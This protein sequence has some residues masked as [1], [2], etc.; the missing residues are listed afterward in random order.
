MK[1]IEDRLKE[2]IRSIPPADI[3]IKD[4]ATV[5]FATQEVR[6]SVIEEIIKAFSTLFREAM[7]DIA[8]GLIDDR[9]TIEM[10]R[11]RIEDKGNMWN[12]VDAMNER[13]VLLIKDFLSVID[14]QRATIAHMALDNG[15]Q[16]GYQAGNK[17]GFDEGYAQ[18]WREVD[19]DSEPDE[20]CDSDNDREWDSLLG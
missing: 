5:P 9:P 4:Y 11:S 20:D 2:V 1:T 19:R 8:C 13:E 6:D 10:A 3:N 16:E 18:A 14:T 12:E 17:Q 7:C 15:Y